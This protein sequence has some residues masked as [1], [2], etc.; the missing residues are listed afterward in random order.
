MSCRDGLRAHSSPARVASTSLQQQHQHFAPG[1]DFAPKWALF[2]FST[3]G[4]TTKQGSHLR[5]TGKKNLSTLW[6]LHYIK[7]IW[8]C[9]SKSNLH[10][11]FLIVISR[12]PSAASKLIIL[13]K[14]KNQIKE[15]TTTKPWATIQVSVSPYFL[16]YYWLPLIVVHQLQSCLDNRPKQASTWD[17]SCLLHLCFVSTNKR[18]VIL[19]NKTY[20]HRLSLDHSSFQNKYYLQRKH[21]E[22]TENNCHRQINILSFPLFIKCAF[23]L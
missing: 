1:R 8:F 18:L 3:Q 21:Y 16:V 19:A 22:G 4:R 17:Y 2:W 5:H 23:Y 12:G 11:L 10:Y 6:N 13:K 14:N 15:N 7:L 9:V 20:K